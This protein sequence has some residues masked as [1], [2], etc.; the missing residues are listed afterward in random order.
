[1]SDV[2]APTR[3]A[4]TLLDLLI[5][6]SIISLSGFGGVLYWS[7]RMMV[8]ERK[9]LTAGDFNEA[10]ALCNFL[11]GPNIVNF[12]VVF[13]R[14]IAGTA[15]AL[16]ALLGLLGP[17]FVIV[18]LFGILYAHY[19]TIDALQRMFVGIAA[20]GAGLTVSTT[21]KMLQPM[22]KERFGVAHLMALAAFVGVGVLRWPI[23]W[24]LG[25]LMPLSVALA[26]WARR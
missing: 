9:W 26:W 4:P 19:G 3:S 10:Y 13:G 18:T 12:S 11:P 20:A 2:P 23:Y 15:G 7:R 16:V 17:P 8:E 5:A 25:A 14:Q 24:V 6:F 21:I 1:M 22:L